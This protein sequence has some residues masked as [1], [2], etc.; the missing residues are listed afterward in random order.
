MAHD[1]AYQHGH[2]VEGDTDPGLDIDANIVFNSVGEFLFA[3]CASSALWDTAQV[4]QHLE[5]DG[6]ASS[7]RTPPPVSVAISPLAKGFWS[8]RS[9]VE[10]GARVEVWNST[11]PTK[12]AGR[13]SSAQ[14]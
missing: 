14:T 6:L 3:G 11:V 10:T 1:A 9:Q 8:V 2:S 13:F 4:P 12:R 7:S 5:Q